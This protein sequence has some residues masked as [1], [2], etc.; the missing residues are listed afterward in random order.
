MQALTG[1]RRWQKALREE[2]GFAVE[3][4][5]CFLPKRKNI[6]LGEAWTFVT[7]NM[8]R[9]GQFTDHFIWYLMKLG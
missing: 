6:D 5:S 8:S 1:L 3:A 2:A 9:Y 7:P 4:F